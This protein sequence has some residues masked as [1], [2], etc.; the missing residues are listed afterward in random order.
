MDIARLT[1]YRRL[2]RQ[3]N[4]AARR[5]ADEFNPDQPREADGKWGAGGSGGRTGSEMSADVADAIKTREARIVDWPK[6]HAFGMRNDGTVVCS[7][8]GETSRVHFEPEEIA[9]F[10]DAT[11]TH[12]HPSGNSLSMPD[13]NIAIEANM[14]SMRAVGRDKVD[15]KVYVYSVN[16]PDRGWPRGLEDTAVEAKITVE[17]RIMGLVRSNQM[18]EKEAIGTLARGH[19]FWTNVQSRMDIGYRREE[20]KS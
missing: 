6:E 12:N 11:L 4:G 20:V 7:K 10:Q 16:R 17:N 19:E 8:N 2:A 9:K 5:V 3:G 13:V 14:A 18:N 15:G 1:Y